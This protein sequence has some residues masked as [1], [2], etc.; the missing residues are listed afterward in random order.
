MLARSRFR[1]QHS[2]SFAG[3]LS[4]LEQSILPEVGTRPISDLVLFLN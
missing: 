2:A 1:K 4:I 3:L